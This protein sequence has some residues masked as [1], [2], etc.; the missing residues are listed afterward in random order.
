MSDLVTRGRNTTGLPL[1]K[2]IL[3]PEDF[4]PQAY[5]RRNFQFAPSF[6]YTQ[7]PE[8]RSLGRISFISYLWLFQTL[9][10]IKMG[11]LPETVALPKTAK[12]APQL[13][14]IV[15]KET[16]SED[17]LKHYAPFT[18][19]FHNGFLPLSPPPTTLPP[20]FRVLDSLLKRAPMKT[21][22]G[23][24][25]L[26][27]SFTFGKAVEDE[28]PDLT[29]EIHEVRDDLRIVTALYRDYCFLA[30]AYLLEPCHQKFYERDQERRLLQEGGAPKGKAK[31]HGAGE[32]GLA[33][34]KLP[35]KLAVPLAMV[36]NM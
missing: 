29:Y 32:Y 9:I 14:E 23:K 10:C 28:L 34:S 5:I 30:S 2:P 19:S 27:A 12:R 3:R 15:L 8:D 33:R 20:A 24:E 7:A 18:V 16:P 1:I 11:S 13:H 25:G 36:A 31:K 21:A 4:R 26:L 22:D 35:A 6:L 17:E